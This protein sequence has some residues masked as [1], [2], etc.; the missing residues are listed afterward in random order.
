MGVCV[1]CGGNTYRDDD[2]DSNGRLISRRVIWKC[3]QCAREQP[4]FLDP[5][6][7]ARN[8]DFWGEKRRRRENNVTDG[9]TPA[10]VLKAVAVVQEQASVHR[11]T[12]RGA[13]RRRPRM[14]A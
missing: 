10:E 13:H 9:A 4:P 1:R 2:R 12:N 14:V 8:P 3:L 6:P 5:L 7:H 11:P